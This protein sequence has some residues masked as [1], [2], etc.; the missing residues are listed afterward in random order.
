MGTKSSVAVL[1]GTA[2]LPMF[3]L[4]TN[5]RPTRHLV[6]LTSTWFSMVSMINKIQTHKKMHFLK[7]WQED[8]AKLSVMQ[9]GAE[10]TTGEL[11]MNAR[12]LNLVKTKGPRILSVL[13]GI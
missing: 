2:L 1:V 12:T 9:N 8:A 6:T 7:F 10:R 4:L 3:V 11:A 5:L 13:L